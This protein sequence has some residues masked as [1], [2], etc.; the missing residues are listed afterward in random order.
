MDGYTD[1]KLIRELNVCL[2][3]SVIRQK[4]ESQNGCFKKTKQVKF[5]EKETFLTP[6]YAHTCGYR[7]VRNVRFR[8]FWRALF[9]WNT[10]FDICPFTLLPMICHIWGNTNPENSHK[11]SPKKNNPLLITIDFYSRCF[12]VQ[13]KKKCES[14]T[15]PSTG[16]GLNTFGN[17]PPLYLNIIFYKKEV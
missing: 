15:I 9:S 4:G 12:R 17:E 6:W 14:H 11:L 2:I 10:R 3:S 8:K 1:I 13:F 5:S 7:V 16:T